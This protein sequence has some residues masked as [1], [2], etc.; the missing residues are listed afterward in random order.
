MDRPRPHGATPAPATEV[1]REIAATPAT[2]WGIITDPVKFS[3]WMEGDITF[4]PR[5]GRAFRAEFPS[6]GIVIGGEIRRV[7]PDARHLALTWGI[8]SGPQAEE[9]PAGS[10]LV[11]IRVR[12]AGPGSRADVRHT[13]LPSRLAARQ[14][15]GGW[16]FQLSRLDLMANRIDLA[17]GL[18]RSLPLWVAAWNEQDPE[19]RIGILRRICDEDVEFRDDWTAIRGVDLLNVHIGNCHHYM[20]GYSLQHTGDIRICRGEALVGWHATGPG[21]GPIEGQNHMRTDPDGTIRRVT[22]FQAT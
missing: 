9:Y 19:E 22:G 3:A 20:P 14:Q 16:R 6:H 5:P 15:E 18:E 12:P 17:A 11:E 10:S 1:S 7:D 4:E 2:V 8:E 13:G 21:G